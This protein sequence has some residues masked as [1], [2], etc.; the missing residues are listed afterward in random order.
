MIRREHKL[1]D[2]F[3]DKNYH[4][5]KSNEFDGNGIGSFPKEGIGTPFVLNPD[6]LYI[7]QSFGVNPREN[8]FEVNPFK[9]PALHCPAFEKT[10]TPFELP[11]RDLPFSVYLEQR[12]P[13]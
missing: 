1:L 4:P 12:N 13:F 7:G 9:K 11:S 2:D 6:R 5:L 8:P 3:L 10:L